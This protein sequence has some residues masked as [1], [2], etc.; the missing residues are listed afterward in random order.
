MGSNVTARCKTSV[1]G[2]GLFEK[3]TYRTVQKK[4]KEGE[5]EREEK[6]KKKKGC[7][8]WIFRRCDIHS[9]SGIPCN[10]IQNKWEALG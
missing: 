2:L 5:I 4:K 1:P 10:S 8:K 7:H 9:I 3:V 6:P